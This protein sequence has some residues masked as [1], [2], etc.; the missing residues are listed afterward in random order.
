MKTRRLSI[1]YALSDFLASAITWT[2]F[3]LIRDR[4]EA[5][6][7]TGIAVTQSEYFTGLVIVPLCWIILY[8]LTGF[9]VVSLKRSRL[10]E[11]VY[12]LAITI[13]G[14]FILFF[15]LLFRGFITDNSLFLYFFEALFLLQFVLTY[16]PRLI[17]TSSTARKVHK[18]LIGF[19]TVIIGSNGK[20]LD[21]YNRIKNE[22]IPGGNILT[23]YISLKNGAS[24][25][26]PEDL[27]YLGNIEELPQII[28]HKNIEEVIIAIEGDEH[29]TISTIIKILDF[30]DVTIKAIPS[31]HDI[32]IGRVK[33]TAIFGTPLIEISNGLMP[34]WQA[35]IKQIMDYFL[36]ILILILLSPI[37]LILI[38]II[39]L[40]GEGPVIFSQERIGKNGNPF[41][42]YKFRSMSADAEHGEPLLSDKNDKRVTVI[43]RFMRKRR[44]DEI[45]NLINVIKGEMSIVGPRPER[46]FFIDQIVKKAPHYK[47]LH[48]VRP[49]ITSWGQV[50]YG[51]ASNVNEMIERLEYDLLYLENMSL[52]IDLKIIIYT[53]IIIIKGKGV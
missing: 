20:A 21:V 41:K 37:I 7:G 43:G 34:V 13:P 31:L 39:K 12:S 25:L 32:L 40:S 44:F 50:K 23:G 52:S 35:N 30:S 1:L 9:Y 19:N 36:A 17:I 24:G 15:I 6:N 26:M 48:K 46:Q 2:L 10:V 33:Q 16:I 47:R 22:K 29:D 3:C 5:L 18:G 14:V 11:L 51:Y 42:I 49:G 38:V 53:L 27:K 45:P 8:L 4:T 28:A